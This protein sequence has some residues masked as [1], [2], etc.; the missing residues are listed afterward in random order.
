MHKSDYLMDMA[1]QTFCAF[2]NAIRAVAAAELR[3]KP[4]PEDHP[5]RF[6]AALIESA[7]EDKDPIAMDNL[8]MLVSEYMGCDVK[9][10]AAVKL[11]ARYVNDIGRS[12]F[13]GQRARGRA[14]G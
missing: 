2:M 3:G 11:V 6:A 8:A 12:M 10:A 1:P 7:C 14:H 4:R 5:G 9:P 13:A